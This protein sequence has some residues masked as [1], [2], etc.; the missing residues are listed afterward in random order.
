[1]TEALE[2]TAIH[3]AGHAVLSCLLRV[4]FRRVTI[5]PRGDSAGRGVGTPWPFLF[6]PDL[7][8]QGPRVARRL[9]A[10]IMVLFG[11]YLAEVER[12]GGEPA[13][14]GWSGDREQIADLGLYLAGP[15][16][17]RAVDELRDRARG[18]LRAAWPA[19]E[20]TAQKLLEVRTLRA[21][22]ARRLY[23]AAKPA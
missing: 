8:G 5:K 14:W 23:L 16:A 15:Q 2:R 18:H 12:Y 17:Q 6:R 7:P 10:E 21:A 4:P 22:E 1:M 9:E 11:G 20:A 19:V 13:E 3:E